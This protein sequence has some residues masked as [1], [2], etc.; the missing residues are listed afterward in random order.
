[1]VKLNYTNLYTIVYNN[2]NLVFNGLNDNIIYTT[3]DSIIEQFE[4]D[5]LMN[6]RLIELNFI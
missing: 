3:D 6:N 4:S 1:M 5:E 2:E